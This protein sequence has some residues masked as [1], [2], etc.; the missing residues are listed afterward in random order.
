M[1]REE[2]DHLYA[3]MELKGKRRVD[4]DTVGQE[5]RKFETGKKIR[6][7]IIS[8]LLGLGCPGD[9]V[10]SSITG[11]KSCCECFECI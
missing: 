6:A 9:S 10:I 8:N 4:R 2:K 3:K 11:C 1:V 7:G 5:I